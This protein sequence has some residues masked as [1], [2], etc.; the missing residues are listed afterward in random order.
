MTKEQRKKAIIET[1]INEEGGSVNDRFDP[2]KGTVCGISSKSYPRE[3]LQAMSIYRAQGLEATKRFAEYFYEKNFWSYFYNDIEDS[4]LLQQLFDFG[5]NAGKETAVLLLQK[6][7]NKLYSTGLVC[8][9]SFGRLTLDAVNR[10]SKESKKGEPESELHNE[11]EQVLSQWYRERKMFYRFG[12][13]W[14]A[15]LFRFFNT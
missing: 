4:T 14:I 10:F 12:K 5:V 8:D 9:G 15:R 1:T 13:G 6:T 2:G 7:L 3:Y 11:Y